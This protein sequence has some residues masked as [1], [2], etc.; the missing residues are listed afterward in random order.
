VLVRLVCGVVLVL[1]LL[2][3]ESMVV[4]WV[5]CAVGSLR[6]GDSV[7]SEDTL[8][9]PAV[10]VMSLVDLSSKLETEA[11][12]ALLCGVCQALDAA[13]SSSDP[14]SGDE[15]YSSGWGDTESEGENG[16]DFRAFAERRDRNHA[17]SLKSLRDLRKANTSKTRD[18]VDEASARQDVPPVLGKLT[19]FKDAGFAQF[20]E[21]FDVTPEMVRQ[22]FGPALYS[23]G[24]L[25]ARFSSAGS[26]SFFCMSE[27]RSLLLKVAEFKC[28]NGLFCF[29]LEHGMLRLFFRP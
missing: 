16:F 14:L 15:C 20:R 5:T 1:V 8:S 27:D 19:S 3:C 25:S 12:F 21:Q 28:N 22:V 2:P 17:K 4:V 10:A 7:D 23:Q 24:R 11:C 13:A 29:C 6:R 9:S 26:S 18:V